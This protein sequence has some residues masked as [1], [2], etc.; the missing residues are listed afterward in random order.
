MSLRMSTIKLNTIVYALDTKLVIPVIKKKIMPSHYRKTANEGATVF[1]Q[2]IARGNYSREAIISN[3]KGVD[4]SRE[5]INRGTAI[6]RGN[7]VHKLYFWGISVQG[8][9]S[10]SRYRSKKGG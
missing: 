3:N 8:M 10:C 9:L 5:V 1:P 2:I 7:T 6:I 4:Y